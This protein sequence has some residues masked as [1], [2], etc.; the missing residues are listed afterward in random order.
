MPPTAPSNVIVTSQTAT[1]VSLSWSAS[2]D[3][4][5]VAGYTVSYGTGSVTVSGTSAV[6]GGL[7]P[8]TSY[9]FTVTARDAAGNL[10]PG[11]RQV[12]CRQ[13]P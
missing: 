12:T 4:V 13:A 8:N 1:S 10:S 2:T 11:M 5:G 9:R 7:T 6:I 3:N